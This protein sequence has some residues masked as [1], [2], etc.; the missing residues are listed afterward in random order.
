MVSPNTLADG[1]PKVPKGCSEG[2]CHFWHPVTL[3][4]SRQVGPDTDSSCE[5]ELS[6]FLNQQG[7]KSTKRPSNALVSLLSIRQILC[8]LGFWEYTSV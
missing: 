7:A 4:F 1:V 2:F 5:D 8:A 3:G 6:K